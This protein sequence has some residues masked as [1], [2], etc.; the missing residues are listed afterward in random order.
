MLLLVVGLNGSMALYTHKC[1]EAEKSSLHFMKFLENMNCTLLNGQK[2]V[3]KGFENIHNNFKTGVGNM[4]NFLGFKNK[5]EPVKEDK[6]DYDINVRFLDAKEEAQKTTKRET[7]DADATDAG[8]NSNILFFLADLKIFAVT[9]PTDEEN[10]EETT[11]GLDTFHL[12]SAPNKC[13]KNQSFI[14]GRCR[15]IV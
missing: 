1:K 13:R 14:Q 5:I 8:K 7:E 2:K 15:T 9:Q 3:L 10:P 6:L 12:F 11:I 4:K